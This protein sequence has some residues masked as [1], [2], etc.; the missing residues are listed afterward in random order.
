MLEPENAVLKADYARGLLMPVLVAAVAVTI[1]ALLA[2]T[3]ATLIVALCIASVVVTVFRFEWFLYAQVFLLPWY[4][5]VNTN[6]LLRDVSLL[7]RFFLLAGVWIIRS[8]ENRSVRG[9]FVGN[10]IKKGILVFAAV[11]TVSL[12]AS[13]LGPNIDAIRLLVRLFSYLALFFAISGWIETRKEIENAIKLVFYSGICV[14]LFGLYQVW[15]NGYSDLYFYLYPLQEP[16]LEPWNGRITSFLFHFNSLAGY[17]NLILPLSVTC[18]VLGYKGWMRRLAFACYT[19]GLSALYFTGSRG[20]LLAHMVALVV[21][22]YF[23]QPKGPRLARIVRVVAMAAVVVAFLRLPV[24][25][26]AE[27]ASRLQQIDEITSVSRLALWGAASAMFLDHPVLGVGY[28]N[29]R[30]LY[31]DYIPGMAPNQL[32]AHNIYLQM[33]SEMGIIGFAA[34]C[35]LIFSLA[36]GALKLVRTSDPLFHLIGIGMGGALTATLVHG[37]VDYLFNVSPQFGGMFWLIMAM[38]MVA[39]ELSAQEPDGPQ[40]L[41]SPANPGV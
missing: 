30:A 38:G 37:M 27:S 4:P 5:L 25:R 28:G 3:S 26:E 33:L 6:L 36:A 14:A 21:M 17:L 12:L 2:A 32:D 35:F 15:Q 1:I 11:A 19:L 31:N 10:K 20:G 16:S 41:P 22:F 23:F 13:A 24:R 8:R 40:V 34:F 9:W 7:L 18:A 29:Y 39:L